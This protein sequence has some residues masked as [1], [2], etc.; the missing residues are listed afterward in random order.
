MTVQY[1]GH[2]FPATTN[3]DIGNRTER[4]QTRFPPVRLQSPENKVLAAFLARCWHV[5]IATTRHVFFLRPS[6][7]R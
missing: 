1:T 6:V 4:F 7:V 5:P 2:A 3:L